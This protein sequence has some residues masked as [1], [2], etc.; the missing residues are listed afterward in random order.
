ML[1]YVYGQDE[2]VA[3]FVARVSPNEALRERGFGKNTA[4]GVIDGDGKLIGGVVY[5]DWQPHVG[6]IMISA[7]GL[8]TRN[9]F[10]R[11]TLDQMCGYAFD[12]CECQMVIS[13]IPDT[14]L[15][16]GLLLLFAAVGYTRV[17]VARLYG[18]ECDGIIATLTQEQWAESR[19]NRDRHKQQKEA[20]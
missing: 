8:P 13:A 19:F 18:R 15:F 2:V 11:D 12:R 6:T 20:A 7:A 3:Q 5:H 9:W 10:T 17:R 14:K 1:R 16:E 4:M